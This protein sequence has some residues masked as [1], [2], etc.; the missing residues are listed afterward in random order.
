MAQY[1]VVIREV[2]IHDGTGAAAV[3]GDV[4]IGAIALLVSAR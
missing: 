3:T 2:A 4:A 1:D